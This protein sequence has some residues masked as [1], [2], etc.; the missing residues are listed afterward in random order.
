[1]TEDDS[2]ESLGPI[3]YAVSK[4]ILAYKKAYTE[5]AAVYKDLTG[6][7][8][9]SDRD[10]LSK[11]FTSTVNQLENSSEISAADFL[12]KYQQLSLF[13]SVVKKFIG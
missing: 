10:V 1:M 2:M 12:K 4:S 8:A 13:F 5:A 3:F 9:V 11:I 7:N 6:N